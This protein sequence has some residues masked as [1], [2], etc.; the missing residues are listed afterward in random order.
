MHCMKIVFSIKTKPIPYGNQ[1]TEKYAWEYAKKYVN[2]I[3]IYI[4]KY[5]LY[6]Y[7]YVYVYIYIYIYIFFLIYMLR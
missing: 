4:Y 2:S 7:K 3:Y 5:V 1:S 6:I